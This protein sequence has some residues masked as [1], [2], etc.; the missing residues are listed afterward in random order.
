MPNIE[1]T[2]F[3]FIKSATPWESIH[4]EMSPCISKLN[5][6]IS[7]ILEGLFQYYAKPWLWT[8]HP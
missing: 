1:N 6:L 4:S 2:N 5:Y 8:V 7:C 3:N